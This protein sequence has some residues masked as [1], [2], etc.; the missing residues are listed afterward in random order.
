ML[1]LL[2]L[3]EGAADD[4]R[5]KAVLLDL[6]ALTGLSTTQAFELGA[7]MK[8]IRESGKR[9]IARADA[10]GQNAYLLAS[11]ADEIWMNPQ[12]LVLVHGLD[13]SPMYIKGALD[14]LKLTMNIFRAGTYKDAVEPYMSQSMSELSK[15]HNQSFINVRWAR[16]ADQ[17][18]RARG[19]SQVQFAAFSERLHELMQ[20]SGE[21]MAQ[22][23]LSANM[24]D[25]LLTRQQ[26][27]QRLAELMGED[28]YDDIDRIRHGSYL[29]ALRGESR[30][31]AE[32]GLIV[33]E[34]TI[35]YGN[36]DGGDNI[37]SAELVKLLERAADMDIKGLM[38]R[39]N[40]PGGSSFA[41]EQIRQA[42]INLREQKGIPVVVFMSSLA[43]SGGY[44]I[45][46]DADQIW[47][48]NNTI[49]G[50]I[51]AFSVFPTMENSLEHIGI[52]VDGVRTSAMA[53][54][55]DMRR[56]M[57]E[58]WRAVLQAD[59]NVLYEEFVGLVAESRELPLDGMAA[60]AEGRIW[61]GAE[62][63]G[64]GLVDNIGTMADAARALADL[65]GV[66]SSRLRPVRRHKSTAELIIE[67]LEDAAHI[68]LLP[69]GPA[70]QTLELLEA[71]L[72]VIL[73]SNDPRGQ[74][75]LCTPCISSARGI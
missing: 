75:L 47:A 59:L 5:I 68:E 24:V 7:L 35:Y 33:A 27:R 36:G 65:A 54:G 25:Q 2:E 45:A 38:L 44:W 6:N 56:A 49:T 37:G 50:S 64:L 13:F 16:M 51:G 63:A 32:L 53:G 71:D 23:A 1:S 9:V 28:E 3:L 74:Y 22:A 55:F 61:N 8:D 12:G 40:S 66:E 19:L 11:F 26:Q 73:Q 58:E 46:A 60:I 67:I 21:S 39:I 70:R 20:N 52:T 15:A 18:Q 34:G 17:I 42:L 14:K 72:D 30:D 29:K 43:A 4:E 41:S 48:M 10:F 57:S 31:K 62:A 69:D